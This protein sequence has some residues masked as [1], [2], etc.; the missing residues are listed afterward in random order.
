MAAPV[1]HELPRHEFERQAAAR[2]AAG[3]RPQESVR[4]VVAGQTVYEAGQAAD[5]LYILASGRVHLRRRAATGAMLTTDP[6]KPGALF[7]LDGLAGRTY[8]ESA[9]A[10][11]TCL[12]RAVPLAL[13]DRL[14]ARQPGFA[15]GIMEALLRRRAAAEHMVSR[16]VVAGVPG[17]LAGA[18]LDAAEEGAVVG[19]TRQ[20]LAEAAWTTRETATRV[21][22]HFADEGLVQIDGRRIELLDLGRLRA[23]AAG[24]RPILPSAA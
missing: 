2:F 15:A 5:T 9:L 19:L 6:L 23:L 10:V 12:V 3:E 14:L 22:Y 16:A 1:R 4:R 17:R 8:G 13:L 21:L 7:G 11:R 20:Q 18:L 24:A